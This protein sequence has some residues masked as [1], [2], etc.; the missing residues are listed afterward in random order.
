MQ[1]SNHNFLDPSTYNVAATGV[2]ARHTDGTESKSEDLNSLSGSELGGR[3]PQVGAGHPKDEA[4]RTLSSRHIQLIGIGGTIG[5]AIF[6]QVGTSLTHGGPASLLLAFTLYSTVVLALN[7]C[8]A[9]MVTYMPISSPYVRYADHFIDPALGFVAALN[10]FITMCIEIPF[11]IT[12]LNATLHFWTEKIPIEAVIFAVLIAYLCLN[13]FAVKFY[14]E[15]EFWLALGK[16]ILAISML[17]FTF[18]VMVG[19]NPQH[20]AFGFRNWNPNHVPGAPFAEYIKTGSTGRFLGFLSCLIQASFT[21][22]G[23]EFTSLTAGE[24]AYPRTVL[25]RTFKHTY[26]RLVVFFL[27]GTLCIGILLPYNDPDLL[28]ATLNPRPGAGSSPYVIAMNHLQ[29]PVLPHIF[30]IL[31]IFSIFSAGNNFMYSASRVLYGMALEGQL[32]T[33]GS[34]LFGRCTKSGVP[35]WCVGAAGVFGLLAFLG[36]GRASGI[37]LQWFV[38]LLTVSYTFNYCCI[39][40]SYLRF[41]YALRSQKTSRSSLPY[42]GP[43][44]PFCGYYGLCLCSIMLVLQA[45]SVFMTGSGDLPTVIFVY[46]LIVGLPIVFVAWKILKGSK[47]RKLQDINFFAEERTKVDEYERRAPPLRKARRNWGWR[48]LDGMI[49]A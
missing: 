37:V 7:N 49:G 46:A 33:R 5:T 43:W 20:D 29:I 16:V 2:Q 39:A 23:P 19:G 48:V 25:P 4:H 45:Y 14:G 3:E 9:E 34:K 41:Y 15:A 22:G 12:A 31:L 1:S 18:I 26:L 47:R 38:D 30:N 6:V 17:F 10:F 13:M 35:V 40:L 32:G 27:G 24:A 11:E 8:L 42:T 36:V 28:A 21:V 44:Q